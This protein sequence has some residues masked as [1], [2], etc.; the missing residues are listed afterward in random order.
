MW[1]RI[2][3]FW[4]MLPLISGERR[5]R[6]VP[7]KCWYLSTKLHDVIFRKTA[8][9]MVTTE[10]HK[11]YMIR[12]VYDKRVCT[13]TCLLSKP[14]M[15]FVRYWITCPLSQTAGWN[16]IYLF[17]FI[18]MNIFDSGKCHKALRMK[19]LEPAKRVI[20][21]DKGTG[22]TISTSHSQSREI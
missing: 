15:N 16:V 2:V 12:D 5:K 21:W 10:D 22:H 3:W 6:L 18:S 17:I 1:P 8:I 14:H 13:R 7:P 4:G 20:I 19:K 9:L 11:S